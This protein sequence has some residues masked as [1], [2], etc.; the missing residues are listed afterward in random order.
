[1]LFL[2]AIICL[3]K[4]NKRMRGEATSIYSHKYMEYKYEIRRVKT[5]SEYCSA[6]EEGYIDIIGCSSDQDELFKILKTKKNESESYYFFYLRFLLKKEKEAAITQLRDLAEKGN[7]CA[8]LEIYKYEIKKENN[9]EALSYLIKAKEQGYALAEYE[10]ALLLYQG[11]IIKKNDDEAYACA[12]SAGKKN[13][14]LACYLLGYFSENSIGVQMKPSEVHRWY[15]KAGFQGLASAFMQG[16]YFFSSNEKIDA[17]PFIALTFFYRATL[18]HAEG[19]N[20][21]LAYLYFNHRMTDDYKEK[22]LFYFYKAAED[23]SLEAMELLANFYEKGILV[24]KDLDVAEYWKNRIR[25]K[26]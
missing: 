14:S 6:I 20:L 10:Y 19:A 12:L 21:A 23:G 4:Q 13:Y 5:I 15:Y 9:A 1:M 16:G 18:L 24:K 26:C 2:N 11:V 8:L 7:P 3:R 17:N 22:A 25:S